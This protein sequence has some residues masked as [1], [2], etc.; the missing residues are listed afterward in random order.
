MQIYRRLEKERQ[1]ASCRPEECMSRSGSGLSWA[2]WKMETEAGRVSE[3]SPGIFFFFSGIWHIVCLEVH[4]WWHSYL[5]P[6]CH[7]GISR[8]AFPG[9][10]EQRLAQGASHGR[11]RRDR[12][13]EDHSNPHSSISSALSPF[14]SLSFFLSSLLPSLFLSFSSSFLLTLFPTSF[15]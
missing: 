13:M 7:L 3:L 6:Y 9:L 11:H 12:T 10:Q 2:D 15:Y 14:L 5:C 4:P 1:D 8:K